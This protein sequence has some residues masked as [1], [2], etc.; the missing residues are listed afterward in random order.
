M[1]G[2]C[3]RTPRPIDGGRPAGHCAH[4][5][6]DRSP[7]RRPTL[8]KRSPARWLRRQWADERAAR[9]CECD[10]AKR[11]RGQGDKGTSMGFP[12]QVVPLGSEP[13]APPG[14]I[15]VLGAESGF[16]VPA[17]RFTLLFGRERDDVHVGSAST[18]PPPAGSTAYS[19]APSRAA[20]G[21]C[22]TPVGCRS[23]CP[24]VR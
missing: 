16:A 24:A 17:R 14:A 20:S 3:A 10:M 23:N 2:S 6:R 22:A 12:S 19:P 1:L 7:P 13:P 4:A 9:R 5:A 8:M 18:T 15:V 21:G 11:T